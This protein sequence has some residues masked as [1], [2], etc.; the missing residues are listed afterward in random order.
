MA[1]G[2]GDSGTKLDCT[3][4]PVGNSFFRLSLLRK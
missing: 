3:V 1:Q 2:K 4:D